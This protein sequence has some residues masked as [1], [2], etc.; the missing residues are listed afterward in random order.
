MNLAEN[1]SRDYPQVVPEAFSNESKERWAT[2]FKTLLQPETSRCRLLGHR[3]RLPEGAW[4]RPYNRHRD[5]DA[6]EWR[7]TILAKYNA[8]VYL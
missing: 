5:R 3:V 4:A 2:D 6:G 8:W 7:I 1:L